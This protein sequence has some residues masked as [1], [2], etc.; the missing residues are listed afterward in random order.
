MLFPAVAARADEIKLKDGSKIIG[1]IVGFEDNSFKVKTSYGFAVVQKDQVVSIVVTDSTKKRRT[2]CTEKPPQLQRPLPHLHQSRSMLSHSR[3]SLPQRTLHPTTLSN[4]RTRMRRRQLR[5]MRHLPHRRRMG[6]NRK[7][8]RLPRRRR[9]NLPR[10]N[11]CAKKSAGTSTRTTH[12]DS[13]CTNLRL[14][15]DR[16]REQDFAG[17]RSRRWARTIRT[18]T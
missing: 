3:R 1:T 10:R 13:E 12:T 4:I 14:A 15:P 18:L 5:T 7:L 2:E 17:D 9:R 16:G 11:R 8:P 6:R